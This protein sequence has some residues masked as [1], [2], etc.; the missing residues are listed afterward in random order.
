VGLG[1]PG[2]RYIA[3]R[4][5]AGFWL[6]DN[7]AVQAQV[8]FRQEA[9]FQGEV[10]RV[11]QGDLKY[12]LLKPNTFMN[13]SGQAV[14]A[15]ANYYKIPV[16]QILVVHDELDFPPGKARLKQGGSDGRHNGLKNIIAHL[17]SNQFLRLRLGIGHPGIGSEV[18]NYVLSSPS[19]D[20]QT[21]IETAMTAALEIIPLVVRGE[22]NK[23]MQQLH[24]QT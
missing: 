18:T 8:Q 17:G 4:H 24:S 9:K 14:A 22:L 2:P 19:R 1:N 16:E 12:W 10:C 20:D 7:L 3:T 6:V 21:A 13:H 11:E 15:L 5:N 23:A